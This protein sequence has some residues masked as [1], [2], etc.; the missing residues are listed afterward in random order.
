MQRGG[1]PMFIRSR[2]RRRLW[3]LVVTGALLAPP[4]AAWGKEPTRS[5]LEE[6]I[7]RLSGVAA[8]GYVWFQYHYFGDLTA[9]S[10][11]TVYEGCC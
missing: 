5:E 2:Y 10:I 9:Y 3:S 7:R 11:N 6:R 8:V 1:A 4:G